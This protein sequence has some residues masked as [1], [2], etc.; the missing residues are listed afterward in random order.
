MDASGRYIAR[1][2][3][4]RIFSP[5]L[6]A[7][8]R[9]RRYDPGAIII[10]SGDP[11]DEVLFF[12]DGRAK[13]YSTLDNGQRVLASFYL[14]FDA[15]G[16]AELFSSERYALTI[17]AITES[18][19]LC[20]SAAA[21]LG[22]APSNHRLLAY[23]CGRL[24]AKLNDRFTAESI[25]L[26]YPVERRLASYLLASSDDGGII[27]ADDLGDLADYIGCSYRQLSRVVRDFRA[28]GILSGR[29][30]GLTVADRS[31]LEPLAGDLYTRSASVPPRVGRRLG[32][33]ERDDE[34]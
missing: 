7:A 12:V 9:L 8:L 30:G 25:N 21:L 10:R 34:R 26:R 6:L 1:Y 13:A 11:V 29:R 18:T 4:S 33:L 28:R 23:L 24:G 3:L 14:P 5:E 31:A 32:V 27:A 16:E 20:L 2:E 19:C 15:F 17:E 22:A